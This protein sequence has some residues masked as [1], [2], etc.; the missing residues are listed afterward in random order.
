ME[1]ELNVTVQ[2][3]RWTV[4]PVSAMIEVKLVLTAVAK[5]LKK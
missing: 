1:Y 3:G 2:A 5:G 4:H